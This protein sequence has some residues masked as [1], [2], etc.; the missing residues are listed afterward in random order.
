MADFSTFSLP[1]KKVFFLLLFLVTTILIKA[2][3]TGLVTDI[4]NQPIEGVNV[5]LVDQ[6]LLLETNSEGIF[7]VDEN[8][9]DNSNVQFFKFGYSTQVFKYNSA[10]KMMVVLKNL[11]VELDE[12]GITKGVFVHTIGMGLV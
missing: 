9:E 7:F 8:I 2:Q 11:H 10:E 1:I 6:N 12:V 5:L 4:N 3:T